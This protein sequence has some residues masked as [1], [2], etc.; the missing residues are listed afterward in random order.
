[1]SAPRNKDSM[2]NVMAVALSVCFVCSIMVASAA[3]LLKPQRIANKNLDRISNI[4]VA[5]G[6]Q[7]VSPMEIANEFDKF[8]VKVADLVERRVLTDLEAL[9]LGIDT[10]SYDQRKASK[11]PYL[12]KQLADG[13]DLASISRRARYSLLY[14]LREE[15]TRAISKIILPVHGY[16]LWSTLY[17]FIALQGDMNTV[18]GIT[19]YE[20]GETAGLGGEVDNSEWKKSWEGKKI[21]S[22]GRVALTVIKGKA[23]SDS[24]DYEYQ[25]DGLSGATLTSRGVENMVAYWLG[26]DGFGP[27][28]S[29]LGGRY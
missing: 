10:G 17:G 26:K 27:L 13:E 25:I 29:E 1:M 15:E 12:S 2:S 18:S 28:L 8:E 16:G 19:F 11:D 22:D 3:V 5:A 4:L 20:H 6:I 7:N 21:Y 24:P 23:S 14:I 9:D